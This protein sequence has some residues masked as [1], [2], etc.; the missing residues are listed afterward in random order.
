LYFLK[1]H[2]TGENLSQINFLQSG[3]APT[4]AYEAMKK[5]KKKCRKYETIHNYKLI[6]NR[7]NLQKEVKKS[8]PDC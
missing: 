7:N 8:S 6:A 3:G 2:Q 1:N 5:K 4:M